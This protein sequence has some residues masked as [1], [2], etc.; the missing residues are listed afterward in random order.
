MLRSVYELLQIVLIVVLTLNDL[1][2]T[3]RVKVLHGQNHAYAAAV[4]E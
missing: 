3:L 2:Q 4:K 1:E